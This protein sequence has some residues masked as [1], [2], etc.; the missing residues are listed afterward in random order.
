MRTVRFRRRASDAWFDDDYRV[1]KRCVR[2]FERDVR[3]IR[4]ADPQN[5]TAIDAATAIWTKRRR[6]YRNMLRTKRQKFWLAKVESESSSP[7]LLWRSID[8]LLGRGRISSSLSVTA[9]A[10]H[11]FF[12]A[13]VA[14]VRSSTN[15]APPPVFA[16]APPGCSLMEFQRLSVDDVVAAVR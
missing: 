3:R 10:V 4:R 15:D 7:Q 6:E 16:A 5:T 13:K 12:D 8:V 14:G 1:A 11:A 9:D 2:E